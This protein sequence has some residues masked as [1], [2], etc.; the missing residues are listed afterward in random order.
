MSDLLDASVM[1]LA[2]WI[3]A[4]KVSPLELDDNF[5]ASMESVNPA[6]NAVVATRFEQARAEAKTMT[7]A[8]SYLQKHEESL[9]TLWGIPC[10]V[11]EY[12]AVAD[13]P[14]TAAI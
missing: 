1:T 13:M 10:T 11:K 6:M 9:P 2:A 7:Q 14:L 12:I 5:I 4:G 3:R 8:P